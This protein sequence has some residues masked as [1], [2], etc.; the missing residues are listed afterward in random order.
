MGSIW[1][2]YNIMISYISYKKCSL[3]LEVKESHCHVFNLIFKISMIWRCILQMKS[4]TVSK[5]IFRL[6]T[7]YK[8]RITL[9]WINLSLFKKTYNSF[10]NFDDICFFY[11]YYTR[12]ID[13]LKEIL[14]QSLRSLRSLMIPRL[15]K[16][17]TFCR[18][19]LRSLK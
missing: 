6:L 3:P 10:T 19:W 17:P 11:H 4:T 18:D 1:K 16:I 14:H 12:S 5:V 8:Q 7:L 13:D 2:N 9:W 15:A